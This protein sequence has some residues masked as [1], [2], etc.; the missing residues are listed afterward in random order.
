MH[1]YLFWSILPYTLYVEGISIPISI[2]LW[3]FILLYQFWGY[4]DKKNVLKLRKLLYFGSNKRF[5]P[6][7][8]PPKYTPTKKDLSPDISP[9]L[10]FETLRYYICHSQVVG[11]LEIDKVFNSLF[12]SVHHSFSIKTLDTIVELYFCRNSPVPLF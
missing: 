10:I 3:Y 8:N 2:Q 4:K 11:H 9:G 1:R 6:L 7:L 12:S 5:I